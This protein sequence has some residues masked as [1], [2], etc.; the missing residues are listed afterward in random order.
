[1]IGIVTICMII[2]QLHGNVY[3]GFSTTI[4]A[5]KCITIWPNIYRLITYNVQS[6]AHNLKRPYMENLS[7]SCQWYTVKC[8]R[9]NDKSHV[10]WAPNCQR[11]AWAAGP[12]MILKNHV[13]TV[14]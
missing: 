6:V 4:A 2:H 10:R 1:M 3:S 14:I 7:L 9:K 13:H 5:Y 8:Q 12:W 11:T